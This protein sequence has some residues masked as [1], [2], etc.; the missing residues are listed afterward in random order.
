MNKSDSLSV[1]ALLGVCVVAAS[2]QARADTAAVAPTTA[3]SDNTIQEVSVS[4]SRISIAGYDQPTPVTVISAEDL[5][6]DA[7]TDIGDV[8][9]KIPAFGTSSSPF[10]STYSNYAT[11]GTEGLNLVS[12]R[13]LG[14][15]RTLVLVDGQ[16]V[17]SSNLSTGGVDLTNIPASLIERVDVVTGGASAA[18]G[19]DA[20]AGVVNIIL[21]KKFSGIQVNLEDGNNFQNSHEQRKVELSLGTDFAGDRGHVILSGSFLDSPDS[22]FS[23]QTPGFDYQ[24]LVTNP[25]YA[26]GNGQPA[27]IHASGVGLV[28]ATPGGII[29]GGPLKGTYFVGNGIPETFNYANVSS[30]YYTNGGTPNTQ[31]G[32]FN[33]NAFP[34]KNSTIFALG[35]FKISDAVKASL[36]FNYGSSSAISNSYTDLFYGTL[37]IHNDNAFLP[38]QT[39]AQMAAAGVTSFPFGT[40]NINNLTGNGGSVQA[41]ISSLGVPVFQVDRNLYRGVFSLDGR[42]G[43]NWTW[44]AYYQH[45]ES[46][47]FLDALNNQENANYQNAIDAVFVTPANVG[48]SGLAVGTIACRST[49]THP[50]NGCAPL[51]VFGI[52]VASQAAI[53][54]INGA[55]R[56]GGDTQVTILKQDVAAASV[57]GE[58]PFGLP[59]GNVSMAT[60]GEY[61]Q[62]AGYQEASPLSLAGAF[63]LGNFVNF[64]G[65]YHV[66]EGFLELNAPLLKDQG[67]ETLGFNAAG[68]ITSYSSSGTIE[69]WKLG[70]TSQIIDD[71]RVRTSWSYDIR[72][73]LLNDLYN[74]GTPVVNGAID[75]HTGQGVSVIAIAQGNPDLKPEK[76]FT[77]SAGVIFTPH[78]VPRLSMSLDYYSIKIGDAISTYGV[79]TIVAQCAAGNQLFCSNLVFGG[80]NGA[81]SE[82]L[83]AP[84]NAVSVKTSGLDFQQ[85]YGMPLLGGTFSMGTD[86]NYV[87][88][89]TQTALG[90]SFDAAGSIG[91]NSAV[92]GLPKLRGSMELTYGKGPYSLTVQTRVIGEAQLNNAWGPLNVDDNHVPAV[93]YWDLRAAYNWSDQIQFYAA[94][95]N[96][97]NKYPPVTPG[98]ATAGTAFE[99]PIRDSIYDGFGQVYRLGI[100]ATF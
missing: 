14:A 79:S 62:E 17:V 75:P 37:T 81:L 26:P 96:V 43:D 33:L 23:D 50:T 77:K 5:Q 36:Q 86:F 71:L 48:T 16:R 69:T 58:L 24:R 73:P 92:A 22:F 30:G 97:T 2:G 4:A 34:L 31:E 18:W 3:T 89:L 15:D 65:K 27:L 87:Y 45:G 25:A 21:N 68:R 85:N 55:A 61:R 12:L 54:Y 57:Q 42:I 83:Q 84:L 19:S 76:A 70:L 53:S 39:V 8:L 13:Q 74:Q 82:V 67:V 66:E 10:N 40:T 32:D 47:T 49:L 88:D 99:S 7:R 78:W 20:V 38:S 51:N 44:N 100:R 93:I 46:R 29:T 35:T 56:D 60:G 64:Y 91:P 94:L 6:R 11:N 59:A 63:Q 28:Q 9:R 41:G 80:P 1:T 98:S 95:D 72:A 90:T 52:G